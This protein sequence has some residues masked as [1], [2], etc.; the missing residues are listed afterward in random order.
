MNRKELWVAWKNR[1]NI[2]VAQDHAEG[3]IDHL[4]LQV[5]SLKLDS[6]HVAILQQHGLIADTEG[7]YEINTLKQDGV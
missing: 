2:L 3:A 1:V 7:E 4:G 5:A 6:V